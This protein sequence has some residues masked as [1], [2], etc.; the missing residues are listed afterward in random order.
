M[1]LDFKKQLFFK[2]ELELLR[3]VEIAKK[4]CIEMFIQR[5]YTIIETDETRIIAHDENGEN[6]VAFVSM[7]KINTEYTKEYIQLLTDLNMKHAIIIFNNTITSAAK[8]TIENLVDH[9]IELFELCEMQFNITKHYLQPKFLKLTDEEISSID[10]SSKFGLPIMKSIDPISRFYNY[11]KGNI[12]KI[13][14]N[15][16]SIVFR[17]IV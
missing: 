6:V 12:I 17:K 11:K 10:K 5:N 3:K 8:K 4:I 2:M 13:C 14:R 15:D 9:E 1:N 16:N 7:D